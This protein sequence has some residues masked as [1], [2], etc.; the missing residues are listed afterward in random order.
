MK[1]SI[2]LPLFA[3]GAFTLAVTSGGGKGSH[4]AKLETDVDSVSYAIGTNFG[5]GLKQQLTTIPGDTVNIN[6]LIAGF[7]EGIHGKE[8]ITPEQAQMIIQAYFEKAQLTE[9]EKL[10]NEG[11]EFLAKNKEK[12]GI[13]TTAS[14]LQYKIDSIGTGPMPTSADK[15]KVNYKGTLI[16]GTVFDSTD[17]H[18]QPAVFGISPTDGL[19]EGWKEGIPLMPVGSKF[20]FYIPA[21]LAYGERGN[22]GIK[23]NQVL[24]FEIE[25]LGIEPKADAKAKK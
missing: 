21:K 5:T 12:E 22:R 7:V 10:L 15:V 11:E 13:V 1:K 17:K 9:A 18:G 24:I 3:A 4:A 19:I 25:L 23:P 8:K 6:D 20:T 16:D 14:G 2:I